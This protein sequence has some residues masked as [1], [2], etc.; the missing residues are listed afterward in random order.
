MKRMM[1]ILLLSLGLVCVWSLV[2]AEE[3][4]YVI[5]TPK[6]NSGPVPKTGQ[7]D[8]YAAGDDG[9]MEKGVVSPNP[10]FTDNGD[11]TVTDNLTELIWLKNAN[12][13]GQRTWA[14]ALND[15]Y[16]LNSGECGLTDGS[17]QG[18]WRLPNIREL[19]S[20]I[21]FG[22][23]GPA[24]PN[25]DGTGQWTDNDPFTNVNSIFHWSATSAAYNTPL[26]V[27]VYMYSGNTEPIAKTSTAYMW[28]VRSG[29]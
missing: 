2:I 26:A 29:N 7:T 11:G 13:F 25:T 22:Y 4:F 10:R 9:D 8:S 6:K 3:G 17:S 16:T 19:Q 20:L 5:S 1:L 14:T 12:C 28:P 23:Y 24:L 18:D 21:H 27:G 15:C